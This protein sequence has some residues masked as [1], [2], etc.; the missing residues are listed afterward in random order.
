MIAGLQVLVLMAMGPVAIGLIRKVHAFLAGRRGAS[1]MQPYRQFRQLWGKETIEPIGASVI[2]KF[3]PYLLLGTTLTIAL[4]GPFLATSDGFG[5]SSDLFVVVGVLFVG[6]IAMVLAGLD[7]GTSFGGMGASREI[8]VSSL[9]EPTLLVSIFALSLAARS[10]SLDVIC[11]QAL[12]HPGRLLTPAD[13]L[14]L[15]AFVVVVVAESKRLPVDNPTTHLELTMIHEAMLLEYSGPRL[16]VMEWASDIRFVLLLALTANLFFPLGVVNHAVNPATLVVAVG[17]LVV[18]V[19]LLTVVIAL[20]ETTLAK[21]RIGRIPEL[22]SGSFILAFLA[23][24]I[25][26]FVSGSAR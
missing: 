4:V 26:F 16:A 12:S 18:K 22:L 14:T 15:A 24:M 11:Q 5:S 20:V 23:I 19:L 13:L 10:S 6:N 7:L 1:I 21:I 9:V 2:F 3:A 17:S 25:S 8:M